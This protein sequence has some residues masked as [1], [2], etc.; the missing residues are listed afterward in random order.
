MK[1]LLIPF[2]I[3]NFCYYFPKAARKVFQSA[4]RPLLPPGMQLDPN[5]NPS[6][7][8][9]EQRVCFCPDGDFYETLRSGKSSIETGVIETVTADSIKLESGKELHPDIIVTA[10]GI[11][12]R[13]A[14]GIKVSVDDKPYNVP[15]KFVWKG[16]MLEDLPNCAF[17]IGYVD[18]SWTLGADATAQL[19]C[20]ILKQMEKEGTV[21][22][23]PRMTAKD[24]STM[25]EMPLLRLSSTYVRKAKDVVPK[26]G[27]RG[28]W[29]ARSFYFKDIWMAWFGDIKTGT[30]WV[31]GV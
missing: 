24:K 17:V 5:F 1:W 23:V 15:E 10:T 8:P 3:V 22:V 26:A 21:E 6:Y 12:V 29:R 19:V 2:M 18:A 13:I 28:Q 25:K 7:N 31:R 20:R 11:K 16:I 30:E 4:T 9:F 14:G 27:D